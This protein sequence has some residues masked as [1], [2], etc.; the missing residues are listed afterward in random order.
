M[1]QLTIRPST[2]TKWCDIRCNQDTW[3]TCLSGPRL[4]A[5]ALG[6]WD[7]RLSKHLSIFLGVTAG[8]LKHMV[9]Q[10]SASTNLNLLGRRDEDRR[11]AHFLLHAGLGTAGGEKQ[12]NKGD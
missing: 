2:H 5:L 12:S 8:A 10:V 1:E 11:G 3:E 6:A 4:P 7:R 9:R